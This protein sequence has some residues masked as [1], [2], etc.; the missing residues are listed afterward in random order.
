M[1]QFGHH[2]ASTGDRA[3][4]LPGKEIHANASVGST[5]SSGVM[6]SARYQ[7]YITR[8]SGSILKINVTVSILRAARQYGSVS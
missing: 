7:R 5:G 8:T 6:A 3:R 1:I 2:R 4:E